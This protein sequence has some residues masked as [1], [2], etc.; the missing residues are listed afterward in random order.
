VAPSILAADFARL[1]EAVAVVERAGAE[2]VHLDVMDG[3][4]VPNIT[5]GPPLV[6]ALRTATKL[7]FD[8][9]LMIEEPLRY[10][11]AFVKA[12]SNLLTF[13]IEV[14]DHPR[15]LIEHIRGLGAAVGVSLN[16]DTPAA[17]VEEILPDVDLVL[18]MSV[19][20]GFGGQSFMPQVLPKIEELRRRLRPD[21]RLEVDGGIDPDTVASVVRAGADTL[22]AGS[23]IFRAPSPAAAMNELKEMAMKADTDSGGIHAA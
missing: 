1:A 22:V 16:P 3:H 5:F 11:E 4:F 17:S 18:V 19:W 6:A 13:H 12:G 8:V 15:R 14:D 20:P 2:L 23:A 7:F 9:H 21:Q 10:A